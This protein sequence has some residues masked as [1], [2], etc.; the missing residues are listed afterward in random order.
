VRLI[1]FPNKKIV[2][3]SKLINKTIKVMKEIILKEIEKLR[4]ASN[5]GE[6]EGD[7]FLDKFFSL[8]EI[9]KK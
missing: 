2:Y 3:S 8:R 6:I 9:L 5:N 7:E 1:W 4:V